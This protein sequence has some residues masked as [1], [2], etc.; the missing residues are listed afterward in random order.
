MRKNRSLKKYYDGAFSK[1]LRIRETSEFEEVIKEIQWKGKKVLDVGCGTGE[2]AFLISKKHANV[3]GIDYSTEAI[4]TAKKKYKHPNLI[5]EKIDASKHISGNYDII[6]SIGTLEHMDNPFNLLKKLKKHLTSNGKIIITSPNWTNPR[7]MILMTLYYLFDAPITLADIHYFT[8][9]DF[10]NWATK[11]DM[12]LK[13]RTIENSWAHG[14]KLIH[15][16]KK[17]LPNVLADSGFS[18]NDKK[19]SAFLEWINKKV[20]PFDNLL[21]HSGAIGLYVFFQKK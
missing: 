17:R 15:D 13:W 1:K 9:I 19:I 7:G 3:I 6:V 4:K 2:F 12:N 8:P 10:N 5:Y 20:L 16:L 14:E 18:I 21:P 11:L